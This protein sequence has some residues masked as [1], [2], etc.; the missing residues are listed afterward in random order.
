MDKITNYYEQEEEDYDAVDGIG[1]NLKFIRK[2]LAR[3]VKEI[4]TNETFNH[5]GKELSKALIKVIKRAISESIRIEGII[6][7]VIDVII[8]SL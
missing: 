1:D 5:V 6:N 2:K 4:S 7:I 3:L 8:S